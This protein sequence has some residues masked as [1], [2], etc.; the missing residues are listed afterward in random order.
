MFALRRAGHLAADPS[1]SLAMLPDPLHPAVVHF[2]VV[3]AFLLPIFA[4]GAL[5][6]I[7]KGARPRRAWAIPLALAA[8]LSL[9]AWVAVETGESQEERVADVVADRPLDAHEDAA[10]LFLTLSGVLLLV[11]AAGL[12]RGTPGRVARGVATVGAVA[13][14]A[15][16]ARVGHTGGELVYRYGA[17]SAYAPDSIVARASANAEDDA[18]GSPVPTDRPPRATR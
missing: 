13:L 8:A 18:T 14:V 3:L 11:T 12:L 7:R 15:A 17:G 5:W 2:P 6:A 4:A 1:R 16:A 10:E 9:S